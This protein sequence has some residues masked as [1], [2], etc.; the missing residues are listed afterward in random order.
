MDESFEHT[1]FNNLIIEFEDVSDE[2]FVNLK[3]FITENLNSADKINN[4]KNKLSEKKSVICLTLEDLFHQVKKTIAK[5]YKDA[6]A[7]RKS[8][9]W[10]FKYFMTVNN[11]DDRTINI[12]NK[13]QPK[14]IELGYLIYPILSIRKYK[15]SYY[16]WNHVK[17]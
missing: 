15:D 4:N 12:Y 14:K 8:E 11:L 1:E 3:D 17:L 2:L 9:K 10:N 7:G 5:D 13:L 16:Y 6:D